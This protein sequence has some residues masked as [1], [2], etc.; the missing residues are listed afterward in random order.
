MKS[1]INFLKVELNN[2]EYFGASGVGSWTTRLHKWAF[3]HTTV[4]DDTVRMDD[5][6][7]LAVNL[8]KNTKLYFVTGKEYA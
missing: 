6:C 2:L 7:N 1:S 8:N 4:Y 5:S 3:G